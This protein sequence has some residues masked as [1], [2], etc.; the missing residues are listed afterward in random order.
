MNEAAIASMLRWMR[1]ATAQSPAYGEDDGRTVCIGQF[2]DGGWSQTDG[3]FIPKLLG[4]VLRL[5]RALLGTRM[6]AQLISVTALP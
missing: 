5:E 1:A 2:Q 6:V 4:T 3:V